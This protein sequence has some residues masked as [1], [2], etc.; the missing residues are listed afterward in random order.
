MMTSMLGEQRTRTN[1]AGSFHHC[2]MPKTALKEQPSLRFDFLCCQCELVA[3][4][5]V[6][7][8]SVLHVNVVVY[9]IRK[10]IAVVIWREYGVEKSYYLSCYHSKVTS[11][12][13][14]HSRLMM[15]VLLQDDSRRAGVA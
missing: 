7:S 13:E 4:A 10:I 15:E 11:I 1:G 12:N 9:V 6:C 3:A 5:S 2:Y 14:C 8:T